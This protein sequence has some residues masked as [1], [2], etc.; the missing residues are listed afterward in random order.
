[1]QHRPIAREEVGI[2]VLD[3]RR[4]V[5]RLVANAVSVSAAVQDG[6]DAED[7]SARGQLVYE[8]FSGSG[9]TLPRCEQENRMCRAMEIDPRFVQV[10]LPVR[11]DQPWG[12]V[13][14]RPLLRA[15]AGKGLVVGLHAW[16]R[17]GNAMTSS[18]FTHAYLEDYLGNSQSIVQAQLVSLLAEGVFAQ[19]PDLR[20]SLLE[21]GFSW[22]P[23]LLLL[24]R[25]SRPPWPYWLPRDPRTSSSS[26]HQRSPYSR[27]ALQGI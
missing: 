1:M 26:P 21:C 10:L 20:V 15:A 5:E 18:G 8:P 19:L 25:F 7:S 12:N 22:L 4:D 16:G 17:V 11:G 23:T 27:P 2:Q 24:S 13:R 3:D 9:T 14:H 6:N